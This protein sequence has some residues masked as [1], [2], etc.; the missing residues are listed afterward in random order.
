MAALRSLKARQAQ[1]R[2]RAGRAYRAACADC[3]GEHLVVNE[4]GEPYL[5]ELVQ[6]HV[7]Q[8]VQ[9]GRASGLPAPRRTAHQCHVDDSQRC[10]DPGG[11]G[12]A[13]TCD[14]RIHDGFLCPQ[15]RRCPCQGGG[16]VG[17]CVRVSPGQAVNPMINLSVNFLWKSG[18]SGQCTNPAN[19][20]NTPLARSFTGGSKQA[21]TADPFLVREVLYQLS[22]APG[23]LRQSM[24]PAAA[25]ATTATAIRR[26]R[27]L[28]DWGS[29]AGSLR[30][31]RCGRS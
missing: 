24:Q 28:A 9:S 17:R 26:P 12:M 16:E 30:L 22:Y 10:S 29:A 4:T 27:H 2:L 25:D 8:P 23:S 13:R 14:T 18:P 19:Q 15:P 20:S 1:E 7:Q 6:R 21:R 11:L 3:G 5:P 31:I